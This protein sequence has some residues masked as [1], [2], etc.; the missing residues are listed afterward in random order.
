MCKQSAYRSDIKD[1]LFRIDMRSLRQVFNQSDFDPNF[2]DASGTAAFT[3]ISYRNPDALEMFFN[4]FGMNTSATD[5]CGLD[6]EEY[7]KTS[8]IGSIERIV[9]Q[10]LSRAQ[11]RLSEPA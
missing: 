4:K 9:E 3:I 2:C 11:P 10:H 7:A 1:A 8:G 6:I 5:H